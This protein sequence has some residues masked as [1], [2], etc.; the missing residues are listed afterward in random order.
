M[1]C[2]TDPLGWKSK[3]LESGGA[4]NLSPGSLVTTEKCKNIKDLDTLLLLI[5]DLGRGINSSIQL[6]LNM[7]LLLNKL[8]LAF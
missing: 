7:L 6:N 5:Q 3:V 2:Y 1:D 8:I 4:Q